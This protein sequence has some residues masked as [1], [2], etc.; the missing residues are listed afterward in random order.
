MLLFDEAACADKF[1]T[2]DNEGWYTPPSTRGMLHFPV[3]AGGNN[4]GS[5]AIHPD[6]RI[7]VVATTRVAGVLQLLPREQCEGVTQQQAGTPYCV[8]TGF[9]LSPLGVPCNEPPWG[10][11]DAIDIEAGKLLWSVPMGTTRNMAP[12]PFWWLKGIPGFGGPIMT[13][14]GLVFSG[15]MN[16]HAFRAFSLETGEELW[17]A[18][19]PTAA[20]AIPMTYQVS[21]GGKQYVVIAAG[22]HWSG[23]SPPG[24]YIMAFALPG[25]PK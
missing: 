17:K 10:T 24:D 12:F 20:N 22:G 5:P 9:A 8:K 19:L 18:D 15:V 4:W 11:L 14:T 2:L 3:N 16:E 21:E 6:S 13:D 1:E 23:G 7:M 25:E